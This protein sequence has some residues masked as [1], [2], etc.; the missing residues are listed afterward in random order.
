MF[1]NHKICLYPN[2]KQESHLIRACGININTAINLKTV[3]LRYRETENARGDCVR[4]R[5]G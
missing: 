2:K 3:A 5:K 4:P 1:L